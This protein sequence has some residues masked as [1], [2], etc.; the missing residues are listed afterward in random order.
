MKRLSFVL[1]AFAAI[2]IQYCAMSAEDDGKHKLVHVVC[3]KLKDDATPQ[4]IKKLEQDFRALKGKIPEIVSYSG[5]ANISPARSKGLNHCSVL[6]FKSK[7]DL[8]T[9]DAHEAHK[10]L[11]A[12]M[13]DLVVDVCVLDFWEPE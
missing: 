13:K 4:Q 5:G 10:S 6:T 1:C 11:V 2:S 3:L 7:K 8:E 9:Y 12:S